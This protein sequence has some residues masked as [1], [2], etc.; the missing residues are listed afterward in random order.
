VS[1]EAIPGWVFVFPKE[2]QQEGKIKSDFFTV[3]VCGF[4]KGITIFTTALCFY[5]RLSPCGQKSNS[6]VKAMELD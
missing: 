6:R 5:G 4:L 3:R 1:L 2:L